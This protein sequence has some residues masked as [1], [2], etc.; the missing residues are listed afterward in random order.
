MRSEA[1]SCRCEEQVSA[2]GGTFVDPD[3]TTPAVELFEIVARAGM[4]G[5]VFSF[6]LWLVSGINVE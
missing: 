1:L 4:Y 3:A 5:W 6:L 2:S